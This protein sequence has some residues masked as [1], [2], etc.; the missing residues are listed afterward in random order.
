MYKLCYIW[1]KRIL[2]KLAESKNYQ[3]VRGHGH[4]TDKYRGA[5]HNICNLELNVPNQISVVFRSGSTYDCHF[6]IK[7]LAKEFEGQFECLGENTDK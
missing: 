6:I 7:E 5:V 1:E 2:K 3:K 4:Y